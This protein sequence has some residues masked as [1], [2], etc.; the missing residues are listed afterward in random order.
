MELAQRHRAAGL[1]T[2]LPP[3]GRRRA[4]RERAIAPPPA[5]SRALDTDHV[6]IDTVKKHEDSNA[7]IVRLYEAYGQR[8]DVTLTF[9]GKPRKV[10][11]CDLMEEND[12]PV[13]T[14]GNAVRFYVTPY[15]IRTFKIEF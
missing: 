2:E 9:A 14:K 6:I 15:E 5:R 7:L 4:Q 1:R 10:T 8:G 11:E 3:R 13:K 12:A